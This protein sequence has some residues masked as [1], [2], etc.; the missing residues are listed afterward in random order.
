MEYYLLNMPFVLVC[1]GDPN[2]TYF[3]Q[4]WMLGSPRSRPLWVWFLVRT[5]V[6]AHRQ[7][8][9]LPGRRDKGALF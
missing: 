7:L 3:S 5:C 8:A 4:L 6:L 1:L 2:D 9:S